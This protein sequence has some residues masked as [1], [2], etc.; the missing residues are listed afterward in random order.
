[1]RAFERFIKLVAP[2]IVFLNTL[3]PVIAGIWLLFLGEWKLVL[4]SFLATALLASKLIG[5][6][7]VPQ[8]AIAGPAFYFAKRRNRILTYFFI[9]LSHLYAAALM[10][11]W[12]VMVLDYFKIGRASCRESV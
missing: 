1:M 3:G 11:G 12:S 2:V 7:L 9:F 10:V 8:V 6:A 4:I 5:L